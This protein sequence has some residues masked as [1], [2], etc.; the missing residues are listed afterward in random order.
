MARDTGKYAYYL[1]GIAKN[2]PTHRALLADAEGRGVKHIPTL[3]G[4]RLGDYYSGGQV[5]QQVAQSEKKNE[6]SYSSDALSS[7]ALADDAW[8]E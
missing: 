1:V 6:E 7:A 5:I 4:V 3:I 8:P 2:S